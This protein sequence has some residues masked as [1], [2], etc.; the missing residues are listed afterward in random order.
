MR[1][2]LAAL[3]LSAA[4]PGAWATLAPRSFFDTF[5][6]AGHHWTGGLPPY[7]EHLVTDVGAFYLAFALLFGWAAWRPARELVVPVCLAFAL[8]SALHLGWHAMHLDGLSTF[9]AVAQTVSL[10]AVLVAALGGAAL[11]R[12]R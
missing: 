8:F 10:A 3:S 9:D 6:G 1:A 7:N 5:P 4:Y 2:L 12:V 11:A